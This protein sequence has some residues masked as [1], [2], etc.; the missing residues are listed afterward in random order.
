MSTPIDEFLEMDKHAFFGEL[1]GGMAKN[2]SGR[3]A[4]NLG[5]KLVGG[6]M[7]AAGGAAVEGIGAAATKI[8]EAFDKR[9][10]FKEMMSLDPSLAGVKKENPQLFNAAYSSLRNVNPVFGKDPLIAGSHMH[11][12]MSMG[13]GMAGI[14]IAGTVQSPRAPA[15]PSQQ[16]FRGESL[17][18]DVDPNAAEMS[19]LNLSRARRGERESLQ[20]EQE[21]S[22]QLNAFRRK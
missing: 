17:Y 5:D 15:S 8:Y 4:G 11:R 16:P 10:G 22:R 6:A 19:Q 7:L 14:A 3:A 21:D 20:K 1:M 13:P 12:F 18:Q 2:F 9:R